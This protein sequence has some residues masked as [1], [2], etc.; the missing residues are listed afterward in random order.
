MKWF[1]AA[2]GTIGSGKST[3]TPVLAQCLGW[4]PYDEVVEEHPHLADFYADMTRWSFP[5]QVFAR[6][7]HLQGLMTE[8]DSR[9]YHDLDPLIAQRQVRLPTI[10]AWRGSDA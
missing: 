3:L 2:S 6:N 8:R 5:L 7:L 10:F 4:Q 1:V 9:A